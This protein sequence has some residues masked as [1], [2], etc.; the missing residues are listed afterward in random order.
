MIVAR[1]YDIYSLYSTIHYGEI[2]FLTFLLLRRN[3]GLKQ[4]PYNIER[5]DDCVQKV[6]TRKP[7]REREREREEVLQSDDATGQDFG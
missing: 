4:Q 6:K 2:L 5:T 7:Q 3:K 1:I